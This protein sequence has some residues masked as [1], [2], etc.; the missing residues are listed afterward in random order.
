MDEHV[1]RQFL[2]EEEF[3][4]VHYETVDAVLPWLGHDWRP[5]FQCNDQVRLPRARLL[6]AGQLAELT[7]D[8]AVLF[9]G[10]EG[11]SSIRLYLRSS[12][13]F[14]VA[15]IDWAG[16]E[17]R[18]EIMVDLACIRGVPKPAGYPEA[19]LSVGRT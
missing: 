12:A 7:F 14:A 10:R 19:S 18:V 16:T 5:N 15:R 6:V 17:T 8:S 4:E 13:R 2:K 9:H 3:L 1:H 11:L